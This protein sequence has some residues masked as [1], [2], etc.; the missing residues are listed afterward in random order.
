MTFNF[1]FPS[2]YPEVQPKMH[3]SMPKGLSET[4][5][6]TIMDLARAEGESLEGT[7]MVFSIAQAVQDYL[8]ENNKTAYEEMLERQATKEEE[9]AGGGGGKGDGKLSRFEQREEF[10]GTPVT[11]EAFQ[12]WNDKFLAEERIRREAEL[13][14]EDKA[15]VGRLRGRPFC[16]SSRPTPLFTTCKPTP[17]TCLRRLWPG[18]CKPSSSWAASTSP[19]RPRTARSRYGM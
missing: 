16:R 12:E 19:R 2:A 6:E 10:V 3:V 7:Q 13:T 11:K 9:K 18:I 1:E 8:V 14:K 5:L 4:Q 17:S 15:Q